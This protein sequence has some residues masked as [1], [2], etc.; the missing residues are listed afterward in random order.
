M[1]NT[2]LT[3]LTSAYLQPL[4]SPFL[5]DHQESRAINVRGHSHSLNEADVSAR[6]TQHAISTYRFS[7]GCGL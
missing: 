1:P 2:I 5:P 6:Q 3:A 4:D 7:D